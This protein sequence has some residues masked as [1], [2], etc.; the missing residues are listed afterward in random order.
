MLIISVMLVSVSRTGS[1][2]IR[3]K[4][5]VWAALAWL[6]VLSVK[7]Q[8]VEQLLIDHWKTYGRNFFTRYEH[9]L[10]LLNGV[11]QPSKTIQFSEL[12]NSMNLF[13]GSFGSL[14]GIQEN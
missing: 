5:G 10:E 7:N 2:H 4:D 3:E 13:F 14:I 11:M 9:V 8:S 1:D 6:Q 12:H